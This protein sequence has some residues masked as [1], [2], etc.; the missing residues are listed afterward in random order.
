VELLVGILEAVTLASAL[1]Y[2][3]VFIFAL[4]RSDGP[5]WNI[6]RWNVGFAAVSSIASFCAIVS[7]DWTDG[8]DATAA[9]AIWVVNLARFGCAVTNIVLAVHLW[10]I[11]RKKSAHDE[12]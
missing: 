3:A 8:V 4:M 9:A 10:S 1:A 5:I 6:Y 12:G 11:S 7:I 2:W